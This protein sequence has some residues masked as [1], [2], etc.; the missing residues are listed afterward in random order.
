M[1]EKYENFDLQANSKKLKYQPHIEMMKE[2]DRSLRVAKL[3]DQ[4]KEDTFQRNNEMD[5]IDAE[6]AS[7][8][9]WNTVA[10][11]DKKFD[12]LGKLDDSSPPNVSGDLPESYILPD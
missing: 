6:I 5:K 2:L 3:L 11:N 9:A 8:A 4:L 1:K 12:S 10:K 7:A